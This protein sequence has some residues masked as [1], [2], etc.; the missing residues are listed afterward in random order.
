MPTNLPLEIRTERVF[1]R[2]WRPGDRE[3]FAAMAANPAEMEFFKSTLT[4]AESDRT[5]DAIEAH[6]KQHG[7]GLWAMEIPG[8]APFGGVVG[9][10]TPRFKAHFTPCV[11]IAWRVGIDHWGCGYATEAARAVLEFAFDRLDLEEVVS[12]TATTN[13][14]SRRVMERLGMTFHPEDDFDHPGLPEGHRLQSHVLYR[15]RRTNWRGKL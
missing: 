8:V 10:S 4:R 2:R 5:V 13:V 1:L 14:P 3:V 12:F 7:F 6:F 11:D 15:L 9:L